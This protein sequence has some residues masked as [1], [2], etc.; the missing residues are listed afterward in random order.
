[1]ALLKVV[2]EN[3]YIFHSCPKVLRSFPQ[4]C[5]ESSVLN[6]M[7]MRHKMPYLDGVMVMQ[8]EFRIP[9][10]YDGFVRQQGYS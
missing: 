5:T 8:Y 4:D 7:I 1:M 3:N 6:C 10:S 2:K 9:D